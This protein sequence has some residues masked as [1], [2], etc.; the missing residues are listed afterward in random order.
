MTYFLRR[1]RALEA[2]S[3]KYPTTAIRPIVR[4]LLVV[5][6]YFERLPIW[7]LSVCPICGAPYQHRLDPFSFDGPWWW[8]DYSNVDGINCEHAQTIHSAHHGYGMM[9]RLNNRNMFASG[10]RFHMSFRISWIWIR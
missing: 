10:R 1:A 2:E 8:D 5:D 4:R 3:Y 9:E 6:E 7:T